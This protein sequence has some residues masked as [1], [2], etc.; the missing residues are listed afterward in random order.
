MADCVLLNDGSKVLLNDGS[1]CVLLNGPDVD[2]EAPFYPLRKKQQRKVRVELSFEVKG[3]ARTKLKYSFEIKGKLKQILAERFD[4]NGGLKVKVT[5]SMRIEDEFGH[6]R[7]IKEKL[8][9]ILA[10]TYLLKSLED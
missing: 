10:L 7:Y 3:T 4:L 5:R 1:S 9:K 2:A 6:E 8:L